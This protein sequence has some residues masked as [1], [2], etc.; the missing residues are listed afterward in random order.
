MNVE[1][2]RLMMLRSAWEIDNGRKNTFYASI[3]KAFAGDT[4]VKSASDAIQVI[5]F[6]FPLYCHNGSEGEHSSF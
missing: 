4:A 3:A 2:S 1:L 6:F 5:A